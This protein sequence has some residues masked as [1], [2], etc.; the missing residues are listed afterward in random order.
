MD[1]EDRLKNELQRGLGASRTFSPR[2]MIQRSFSSVTIDLESY[3][4]W[5]ENNTHSHSSDSSSSSK[6]SSEDVTFEQVILGD[7]TAQPDSTWCSWTA[8]ACNATQEYVSTWTN[9]IYDDYES[10]RWARK[11][12]KKLATILPVTSWI[13]RCTLDLARTDLI[14]GVTVSILLI[15]QAVA[16]AYLAGHFKNIYLFPI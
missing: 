8:H 16:Y 13:E 3:R 9:S 14:A 4:K 12:K 6:D 1:Q 7:E 11:A 2:S 10:G 5:N 15:P